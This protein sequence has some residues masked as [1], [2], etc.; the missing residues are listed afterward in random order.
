[1]NDQTISKQTVSR[2][3]DQSLIAY[4][5]WIAELAGR[6]TTQKESIRLTEAEWI[7]HWRE[8][9]KERKRGS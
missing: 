1:M 6:L 9:W 7:A 4:K 3:K 5:D 2:P 8:F